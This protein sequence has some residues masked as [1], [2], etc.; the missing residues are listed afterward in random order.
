MKKTARAVRRASQCKN[1]Q[2]FENLTSKLMLASDIRE[3]R[4]QIKHFIHEIDDLCTE[5]CTESE[6]S[7]VEE[8]DITECVPDMRIESGARYSRNFLVPSLHGCVKAK[9]HVHCGRDFWE[10][11]GMP[12][13]TIAAVKLHPRL[14]YVYSKVC[15]DTCKPAYNLE[16]VFDIR[17]LNF[18]SIVPVIEIMDEDESQGRTVF[19]RAFI[20]MQTAK[21]MNNRITIL[22]NS[23]I[24]IVTPLCRTICGYIQVTLV[25][26]RKESQEINDEPECDTPADEAQQSIVKHRADV[27]SQTVRA[28]MLNMNI[29]TETYSSPTGSNFQSD[30]LADIDE[31]GREKPPAPQREHRRNRKIKENSDEEEMEL[32][33]PSSY[34]KYDDYEWRFP[35][36][37]M[38]TI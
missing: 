36:L 12:R 14:P 2:L 7:E 29:Q 31:C 37:T 35:S 8:E 34:A 24:P 20:S 32:L 33:D 18:D 1:L 22:E 13:T 26:L 21:E 27:S 38:N 25:F 3:L 5:E 16:H 4:K 23:N 19:G 17:E 11:L 9:V 15:A 10:R 28:R 6:Y 30:Y